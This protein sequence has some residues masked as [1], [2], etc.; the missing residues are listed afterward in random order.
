MHPPKASTHTVYVQVRQLAKDIY[1]AVNG[2]ESKL[3][4]INIIETTLTGNQE[5]SAMKK[6]KINWIGED[7]ATITEPEYPKDKPNFEVA[8][9][10]QR[11]R[12]FNIEFIPFVA[13]QND[14]S[15]AFLS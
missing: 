15:E 11:I 6:K 8:L 5:Y 13:A 9:Q 2:V 3:N 1:E 12:A 4:S 10:P 7:D 14:A